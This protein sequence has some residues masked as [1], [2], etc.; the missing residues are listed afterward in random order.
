VK[1]GC[2]ASEVAKVWCVRFRPRYGSSAC[3]EAVV[4]IGLMGPFAIFTLAKSL[5]PSLN[6]LVRSLQQRLRD[7]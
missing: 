3:D 7:G 5:G 1:G 2:A 4:Q 6:H